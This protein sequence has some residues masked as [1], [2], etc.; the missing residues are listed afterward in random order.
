MVISSAP[1]WRW[2]ALKPADER[3]GDI[4]GE[5][6]RPEPEKAPPTEKPKR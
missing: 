3:I 1:L 5:Q 2:P 6:A 4:I